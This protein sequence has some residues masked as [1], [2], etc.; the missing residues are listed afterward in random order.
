MNPIRIAAIALLSLGVSCS[1]ATSPRPQTAEL[2][3]ARLR[4]RAQNLHTYAAVIQRGCFCGNV[5]PL[6][7]AVVNDAVAGVLDLETGEAV[8][9]R[10]GETID[11]LFDF[12]EGAIEGHAAT[13]RAEFDPGRGFPTMI[14]FDGRVAIADDEIVYHV[15]DVHAIPPRP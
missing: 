12:V 3:A 5:N 14:E 6:Y 4:W 8:D 11:D 2:E 1:D 10:L 7:V 13:I 9:T 15:S